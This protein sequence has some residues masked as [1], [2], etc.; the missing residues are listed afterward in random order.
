[1]TAAGAVVLPLA[2]EPQASPQPVGVPEQPE[3]QQEPPLEPAA[4]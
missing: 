3:E 1:L 2:L 4:F